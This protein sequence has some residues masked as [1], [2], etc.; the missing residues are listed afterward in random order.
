MSRKRRESNISHVE[1]LYVGTDEQFNKFL[2]AVVHDY[3]TIA[4]PAPPKPEELV[5][6]VESRTA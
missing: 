5:Q 3:L 6:N 2:N 4:W 1:F